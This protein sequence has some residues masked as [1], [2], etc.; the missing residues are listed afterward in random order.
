MEGNWCVFETLDTLDDA[1]MQHIQYACVCEGDRELMHFILRAMNKLA[2]NCPLADDIPLFYWCYIKIKEQQTFVLY[3]FCM[4][5]CGG[6]DEEGT[7][8]RGSASAGRGAGAPRS[9]PQTVEQITFPSFL[10]FP[11][12]HSPSF[13]YSRSYFNRKGQKYRINT[14]NVHKGF[15]K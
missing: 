2:H 12:Q 4:P 11:V 15:V 13:R 1:S 7:P 9:L 5:L 8:S 14:A 10:Q 6:G 3:S